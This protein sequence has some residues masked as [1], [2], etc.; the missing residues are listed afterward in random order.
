MD[1]RR[2]AVQFPELFA[3]TYIDY[4]NCDVTFEIAEPPDR[5][6][7]RLHCVAVDSRQ[8]VIVCRSVQEWRFLPGGTREPGEDLSELI[9]RELLEEAGAKVTGE[10][11]IFASQAAVSRNDG[12]WR[13]HL[14]HPR[15]HWAFAV[16]DAE[17]VQPPTNPDDGEQVVEVLALPP[18]EAAD[19]LQVHD[20]VCADVVRLA[21]AMDLIAS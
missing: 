1:S 6:V 3:P 18:A 13:S 4:A 2:W 21:A 9:M 14:P 16:V 11:M 10:A 19:W 8:R 15:A 12:P 20:Q 5:L 17:I 7:S